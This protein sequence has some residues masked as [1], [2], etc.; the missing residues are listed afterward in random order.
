MTTVRLPR[1]SDFDRMQVAGK[2]RWAVL[3]CLVSALSVQGQGGPVHWLHAGV[4]PPGAIGRQRLIGGGPLSGYIQPVEI[5]VPTGAQVAAAAESGFG[6]GRKD[7]ILVGLQVGTLYR[8]QVTQVPEHPGLEV[9]P[10]V[11]IIDRLY[12]P[13][14]QALR[15]PI[16]IELTLEELKLAADGHFVTRV[17]YLENPQAA[18]PVAD[19]EHHQR[20]IEARSGEDPL[21]MA[22]HLGRPMAILRLGGRLP[23][24]GHS[25]LAFLYGAPPVLQYGGKIESLDNR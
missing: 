22:D 19:Q 24:D 13:N 18:L 3:L 7:Q 9:F 17:I 16:P 4:M 23:V 2:F 6:T 21:I 8:L 1:Q 11:E 5:R 10:T 20:W 15:F 14:G 25:D 12:P